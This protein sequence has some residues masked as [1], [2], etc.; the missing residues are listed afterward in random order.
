[1]SPQLIKS[2]RTRIE[3]L[4]ASVE[5]Q[6][7]E[8]A[9][10]VRVLEIES[11]KEGTSEAL[12]QSAPTGGLAGVPFTGNKTAFVVAIV[13]AHGTAGATPKEIR[14]VFSARKIA[15]SQNLIYTTLSPL[16]NQKK[17]R[18]RDG[19]YFGLGNATVSA[20]VAKRKIS[21]EGLKG[22]ATFLLSAQA[23]RE[24]ESQ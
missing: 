1:M 15:L 10:Y 21:A 24:R 5:A 4:T 18:R 6:T 14:E 13:H 19:R 12:T 17:L 3:E 20:P 9:A 23:A 11:A 16:A 7:T 8:L 22:C 2:L